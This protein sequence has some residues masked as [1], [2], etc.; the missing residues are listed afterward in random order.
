[1]NVKP[2][3][4]VIMCGLAV[5][6]CQTPPQSEGVASTTAPAAPSGITSS[7]GGGQRQLNNL[8]S[9]GIGQGQPV[10]GPAPNTRGNGL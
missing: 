2:L 3:A 6:G 9:A 10:V 4:V 5:A 8:P 7:N 1:M